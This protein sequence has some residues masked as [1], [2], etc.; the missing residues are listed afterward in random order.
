MLACTTLHCTTADARTD[1]RVL[2]SIQTVSWKVKD[3]E[4]R[5]GEFS[6]SDQTNILIG[7]SSSKVIPLYK[8]FCS[9]TIASQVR[10]IP[11][12]V[13]DILNCLHML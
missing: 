11:I 10:L 7:R 12:D 4:L 9:C 8:G 2:G 6:Y 13:K 3:V 5:K 1:I